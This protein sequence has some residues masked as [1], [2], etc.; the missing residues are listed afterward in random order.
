MS[1]AQEQTA[2]EV[3]GDTLAFHCDVTKEP[4]VAALMDFAVERF[5]RLDVVLNVAGI[6][7]GG[8]LHELSM[9]S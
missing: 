3:G 5:G 1:G 6:G 2:A 4:E 7:M 9:D 8:Q